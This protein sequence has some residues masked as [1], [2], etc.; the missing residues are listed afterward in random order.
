MA[1]VP[2]KSEPPRTSTEIDD[3]VA[4]GPFQLSLGLDE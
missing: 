1:L 2:E 4:Q 3:V